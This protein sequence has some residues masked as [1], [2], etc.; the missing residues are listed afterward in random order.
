MYQAP[1]AKKG[2]WSTGEEKV[3]K[4]DYCKEEPTIIIGWTVARKI[5]RMNSLITNKEWLGYLVGRFNKQDNSFSIT[6]I[7][8]PEQYASG[9]VEVI[10]S[11]HDKDVVGTVHLHPS[12]GSP[13]F[14]DT[15]NTFIGGNHPMMIV[16]SSS[17]EFKGKAAVLL[18]CGRKKF[19]P[20]QVVVNYP[21]PKGIEEFAKEAL[22]KLKDKPVAV[23]DDAV[24]S[25]WQGL[26][27]YKEGKTY[28]TAFY[29]GLCHQAIYREQFW[30]Q[31]VWYHKGC[32]D[33]KFA[34]KPIEVTETTRQLLLA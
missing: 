33:T 25:Y 8:V 22:T 2:Y 34:K 16:T 21:E 12:K 32:W 28:R 6:D 4:C 20:A 13:S 29:C 26:G 15:D 10:D 14:S 1:E 23:V 3:E 19:M 30:H 24:V 27:G 7:R 31:G 18:P 11:M 17:N 5:W 9:M